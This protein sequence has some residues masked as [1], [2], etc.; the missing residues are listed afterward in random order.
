MEI[1]WNN[2]VRN[3]VLNGVKEDR[4]ILPTLKGREGLVGWSQLA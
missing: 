1:S 4:N 2:R 3:K